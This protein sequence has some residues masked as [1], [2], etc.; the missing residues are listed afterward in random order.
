M[1]PSLGEFCGATAQEVIEH[2]RKNDSF[3]GL[4]SFA[5]GIN[6]LLRQGGQLSPSQ[7]EAMRL[8]DVAITEASVSNSDR[9]F[10]RGCS[11]RDFRLCETDEGFLS[12]SFLSLNA[13]PLEAAFFAKNRDGGPSYLL[14]VRIP[15]GTRL[16]SISDDSAA[17]FDNDGW[18]C[19]RGLRFR[20]YPWDGTS[21]VSDDDIWSLHSKFRMPGTSAWS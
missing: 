7:A 21:G 8:L 5:Y 4:K 6:E 20:T 2:Y 19:A 17:S 13:N 16:L 15:A 12:S 18:L 11:E 10:F 14:A 1:E 3:C 9:V